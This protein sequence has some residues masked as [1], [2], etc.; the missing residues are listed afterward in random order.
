MLVRM[1]NFNPGPRPSDRTQLAEWYTALLNE[2][3]R[4]G[5]NVRQFAIRMR[6]SIPSLYQWRRRLTAPEPAPDVSKP[7]LVE[8]KLGATSTIDRQSHAPIVLRLGGERSVEVP[9]EFNAAELKRLVRT[10]E[11]C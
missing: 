2:Q 5:L 4:S 9:P 6:I 11:G 1:E 8:V 3:E 10:L 7:G